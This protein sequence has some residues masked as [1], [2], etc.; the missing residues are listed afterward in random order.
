MNIVKYLLLIILV[1]VLIFFGNGLLT[2]SVDYESEVLVDK[3]V[4]EAWAVMQ[5]ET[6]ITE[7]LKEIKRMEHV[8]GTPG[9]KGAVSK[10]YMDQDG[11]EIMMEETITAIQPN[12]HI[13]M[14]FTMDFMDMDYEMNL[15]QKGDKTLIK[16][17]SKT[18]GNGLFAKSILSFMPSTMKKQEE[19]NLNNLK[20]VIENNTKQYE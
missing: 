4:E 8:S 1:L 6:R 7:W 14:T 15:T 19:I 3:P 13:A 20:K 16:S 17:K 10:Y 2:P 5:D 18:V 9:T 12:K 11:E